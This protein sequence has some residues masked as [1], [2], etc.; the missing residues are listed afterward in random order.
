MKALSLLQPWA[1]LVIQGHKRIETRGYRAPYWLKGKRFAIHASKGTDFMQALEDVEK[2]PMPD[3]DPPEL[4]ALN[5]YFRPLLRGQT[6]PLGFIL[7]TVRLIECERVGATLPRLSDQER[8]FGNFAAGR[9]MWHLEDPRPLA[10]PLQAR[11][12]PGLWL[13]PSEVCQ[14]LGGES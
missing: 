2:D 5:R 13:P 6:L 8:A 7:G 3:D 12:M 10:E 4:V 1:S 9:W 14:Q 11:G